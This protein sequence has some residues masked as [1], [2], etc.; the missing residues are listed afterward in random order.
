MA[1]AKPVP[2]K[3][4][5]RNEELRVPAVDGEHDRDTFLPRPSDSPEDPLN[6]SIYLKVK[7]VV[8][9]RGF[10]KTDFK[11]REPF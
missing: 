3:N 7:N 6:W 4:E 11:Y 5:Q 2:V 9:I 8:V 1:K 10:R